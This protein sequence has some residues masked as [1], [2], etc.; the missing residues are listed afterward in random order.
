[1]KTFITITECGTIT[2]AAEKLYVSQPA[3]TY[4]V[5][6]LERELG[7]KL[8]NRAKGSHS[9]E[10]TTAG[11]AFVG[12]A[13]KLL[14]QWDEIRGTLELMANQERLS[15]ATLISIGGF[16]LDEFC[17][18][19][20]AAFPDGNVY[21]NVVAPDSLYEEVNA[22]KYD[23]GITYKYN[24]SKSVEYMPIVEESFVFVCRK[25]SEYPKEVMV[26]ELNPRKE[27][28][29]YWSSE[30]NLWHDKVFGMNGHYVENAGSISHIKYFFGGYRDWAIFPESVYRGL[31]EEF[32][33]CECDDLPQKRHIYMMWKA[34]AAKREEYLQ[35]AE[36]LRKSLQKIECFKMI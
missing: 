21:L 32:R 26:S 25:D 30:F 1:M 34:E 9:T 2:E 36:I 10:L 35:C 18:N 13:K 31:G 17:E 11:E 5:K 28:F 23:I 6:S 3:L 33:T 7:V 24:N 15:I 27:I 20:A 12:M 22:G 29:H 19:F 4:Q 8:L 16:M 14:E